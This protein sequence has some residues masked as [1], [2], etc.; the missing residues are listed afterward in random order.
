MNV[1]H[2]R[3]DSLREQIPHLKVGDKVF[4]SGTV[5]T[6][7]DA[8]HKRLAGLLDEGLPLPFDLHGSV[9]Y[10][11][12]PTPVKP[13]GQIGSFGPTTSARMDAFSPMLL[14]KGSIAMIGKGNRSDAVI[15]SIKRNRAVYFC[16]EGGMGALISKSIKSMDVIAFDDLGC[17]SIKQLEVCDFPLIV[18][19]DP[20]GNSIFNRK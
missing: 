13:D 7:R 8:A 4:L 18:A 1:F 12:G 11:A 19:I 9:I 10:Y 2:I 3:V 6:A 14:D 5:Y 15:D 17:E 20:S 16:A